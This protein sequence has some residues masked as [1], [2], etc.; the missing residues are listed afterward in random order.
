[1]AGKILMNVL[2]DIQG[3]LEQV[4]FLLATEAS[5]SYYHKLANSFPENRDLSS[6]HSDY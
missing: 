4:T 6:V 3:G 5:Q 1:M 2:N